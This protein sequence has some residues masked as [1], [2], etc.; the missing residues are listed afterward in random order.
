MVFFSDYAVDIGGPNESI[1]P[2]GRPFP[3]KS[4]T[5]SAHVSPWAIDF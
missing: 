3:I 5:L 2:P 4:L 1:R